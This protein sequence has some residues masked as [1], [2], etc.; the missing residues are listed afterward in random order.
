MS[1]LIQKDPELALERC[2]DRPE[3]EEN[4]MAWVMTNAFSEW[5][6]TNPERATAWLDQ[7]IISGKFASKALDGKNET[8]TRLEASL[9]YSLLPSG[10]EAASR[11]L[12]QLPADQRMETLQS[13]WTLVPESGQA[14]F[15]KMVREVLPEDQRTN[16]IAQ[17]GARHAMEDYKAV[18]GYLDRVNASPEERRKTVEQAAEQRLSILTSNQK[19]NV[20][21]ID[22]M[23]EWAAAQ[24][25]GSADAV[26]GRTL[27]TVGAWRGDAEFKRATDLALQYQ[28]KGGGDEVM[29]SFL[30]SAITHGRKEDAKKLTGHLSDPG[31]R[32]EI[33]KKLK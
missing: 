28:E 14:N 13:Q 17:A 7:R 25:P 33:L 27:G 29:A 30:E 3:D 32:E 23:R 11:R 22:E 4:T 5:A 20:K 19:I 12:L 18:T 31:R 16:A 21:D 26:T 24:S 15:A 6:K 9:I 10:P 1:A 2:I 8:R